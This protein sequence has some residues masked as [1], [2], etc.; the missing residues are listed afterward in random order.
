MD[1]YEQLNNILVHLFDHA[2]DIERK[3]LMTDNFKDISVNDMHIIDAIGIQNTVNMSSLAKKVGVTVGTL[4]IAING[5]VRK[6][7]VVR[8][9]STSDRRVVL[10]SLTTKGE[11]A[12]E[13]HAD[14]HRRIAD[15]IRSALS[16]EECCTLV[17]GLAS[18]EQY[19]NHL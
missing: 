7:Y 6:E 17:K 18:L 4:T 16:H 3:F 15:A 1:N 9:R 19:W 5:L 14:F 8:S 2:L 10:V 12:F 13:H 11:Q